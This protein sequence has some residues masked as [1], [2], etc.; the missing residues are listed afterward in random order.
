MQKAEWLEQYMKVHSI[1]IILNNINGSWRGASLFPTNVNQILHL[2]CDATTSSST[3]PPQDANSTLWLL[4]TSSP[5]DGTLLC[6]ANVVFNEA[7]SNAALAT[8]IQKHGRRLSSIA[9]YLHVEN[10]ILGHEN[11]ELKQLVNKQKE[12]TSGKRLIL[13]GRIVVSTEEVY[14]KLAEAEKMTG[15][16]KTKKCKRRD[17]RVTVDVNMD[18]ENMD[19][20]SD[21][22]LPEICN[23]IQVQLD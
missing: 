13:K 9:E 19:D 2:L 10:F 20:N 23:C 17:N 7:L 6:T 16:R 21:D 1:A 8:P 4:V 18:T 12:R 15:E 11:V 3:P 5:P 22:E 14:Q